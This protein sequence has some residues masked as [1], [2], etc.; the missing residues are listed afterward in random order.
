MLPS[1]LALSLNKRAALP[2]AIAL[3]CVIFVY[4]FGISSL[5]SAPVFFD[6]IETLKHTITRWVEYTYTIPE[7][8]SSVSEH[9]V[10][11]G[12][13]YFVVLN[14]WQRLAGYDLFS[15]RLLSVLFA[16]LVVAAVYRLADLTRDREI[17]CAA[18]IVI[19]CLAYFNYYAHVTRFYALLLLMVCWLLWSYWRVISAAGPVRGRRW[20]SLFAATA[21]IAYVNYFGFIII[22]ALGCYHLLFARKDRRWL[23][24][25]LLVPAA[26]LLFAAWLPVALRGFERS[27]DAL[28]ASR[29]SLLAS[30]EAILSIYTNG[31]GIWLMPLGI[32]IWLLPLLAVGALLWRRKRTGAELYL[33]FLA[34]VVLMLL[35]LINE[36]TTILAARRMRYT[37]VL[38]VPFCCFL[39]IGLTKL[40][41]WS[42]LRYPLLAVW[43]AAGVVF[44][45]SEDFQV[46]TNRREINHDLVPH[47]Q[48]LLYEADSL[49]GAQLPILSLH[50][51]ALVNDYEILTY[52]RARLPQWTDVVHAGYNARDQLIFQSKTLPFRT[53]EAIVENANGLWLLHNPQQTDLPALDYYDDWFS[54]HYRSCGSWV[55]KPNA[56]ISF[57]L[58]QEIPCQLITAAQPFALDYDNGMRLGNILLEQRDEAL[59]VYL[60]W[61][62]PIDKQYSYTLQLFNGA[63]EKA[64]QV[65]SVISDDPLD[66]SRLDISGL[67]TGAY[68]LK[69]IVYDFETLASQTGAVLADGLRFDRELTLHSFTLGA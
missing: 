53:Q 34:G 57:Y 66:I 56:V 3:A 44:Y 28:D 21:S 1:A 45:N 24:V 12:P 14:I 23:R 11:H 63:G 29:L 35:L 5:K 22:A 43:I 36:A 27:A 8:I 48:E 39:A 15:S 6:E 64:A 61:R 32:S 62:R 41:A 13:L 9:S 25:S 59:D 68:T 67:P 31:I 20:L 51:H 54:L 69:L 42:W 30:L 40:P 26:C 37:I 16:M 17:A 4:I 65:D 47:Y 18:V 55:E 38:T 2:R 52:Y 60:W 10:E 46:Y 50:Q 33:V 58:K 7:T 49:P 19:A